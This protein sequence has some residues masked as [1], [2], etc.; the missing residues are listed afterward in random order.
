MYQVTLE[1]VS[2]KYSGVFDFNT[3]ASAIAK[4][5]NNLDTEIT[6]MGA[7]RA[8]EELGSAHYWDADSNRAKIIRV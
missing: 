1:M 6:R 3:L 8:L 5:K 2:A 4:V 7:K